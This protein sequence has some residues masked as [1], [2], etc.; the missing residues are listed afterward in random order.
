M[1]EALLRAVNGL[2][3]EAWIGALGVALS[4][5]WML[6]VV[7]PVGVLLARARRVYA[8]VAVLVTMGLADLTVARVFKP[9]VGRERPCRALEELVT[10]ARCGPGRSFPSGHAAVSFAFLTAAAPLVPY[11]WAVLSPL[12][13]G[14]SGSRVLLGVHYPSDIAAGALWGALLG[15]GARR[16]LRRVERRAP[17]PASQ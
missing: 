14:V 5:R 6:L 10:V 12:A 9:L 3:S 16:A 11:G 8:I 1:D 2:A 4:S 7:V 15:L 13:L 17:P